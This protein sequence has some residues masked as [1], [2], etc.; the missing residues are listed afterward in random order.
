MSPMA[1][2]GNAKTKKGRADAVCVKATYIGPAPS[3]TMSHAAPTVCIN[4]PISD[5]TSAISRLRKN[6]VRSGPQKSG[7]PLR[8]GADWVAS[9]LDAARKLMAVIVSL[10]RLVLHHGRAL[11]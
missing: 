1:P 8:T 11:A 3:E 9:A 2:A 5:M 7:D 4:V 6:G 10:D